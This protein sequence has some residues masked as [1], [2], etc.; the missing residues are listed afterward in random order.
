MDRKKPNVLLQLR[1]LFQILLLNDIK[2][3]FILFIIR[4]HS[5]CGQMKG[6]VVIYVEMA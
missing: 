1:D 4:L 3:V 5:K 6:V 2:C